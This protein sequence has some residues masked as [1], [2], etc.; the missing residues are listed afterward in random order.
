VG[1][2][3]RSARPILVLSPIFHPIASIEGVTMNA[4]R[5]LAGAVAVLAAASAAQQRAEPQ[6]T[7]VETRQT[8]L[9]RAGADLVGTTLVNQKNEPLGQVEDLLIHPKGEVAFVEFSGAGALKT[10]THR[11][12]V[13]WAALE[14]NENDQFV[15]DVKPGKFAEAAHYTKRPKLTEMD[16]WRSVDKAYAKKTAATASPVEAAVSLAPGKM[17]FL[18][19]DLRTRMI[20]NPEGEKIATMHELVIDPRSGRV[21]YAVLSVGGSAAAEEKMIAVPWEALTPMPDKSNPDLERL[22]L[23][24]SREQ[25]EKAPEFQ[26]T[27]EGWIEA[28]E[29]DYVVGVY[30]YYSIPYRVIEKVH[31]PE[32][33]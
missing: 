28:S 7:T 2:S 22:T 27:A 19:S 6:T 5:F 25:L 21:A 12:P 14:R 33:D 23:A 4:L 17:L 13:P 29:P 1:T 11:Y 9:L 3:E 18:A 10:G 20:E 8:K 16:W 30:E 26:T 24:T 31:E 15:L 32:K